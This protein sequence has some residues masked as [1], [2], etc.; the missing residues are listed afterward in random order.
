MSVFRVMKKMMMMMMMMMINSCCLFSVQ[1]RVLLATI[2]LK[3]MSGV[4]V[5]I[6]IQVSYIL[7][8][9]ISSD[10]RKRSYKSNWKP[11]F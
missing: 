5:D 2:D 9:H 3:P 7:F 11:P 1:F 4:P 8:S 10:I 6:I